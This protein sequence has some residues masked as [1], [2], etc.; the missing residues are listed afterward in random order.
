MKRYSILRIDSKDF[1]DILQKFKKLTRFS[2]SLTLKNDKIK[3]TITMEVDEQSTSFESYP[4]L[5]K[6]L[7]ELYLETI[8]FC[9]NQL[10]F[11]LYPLILHKH[12]KIGKRHE[13]HIG[14]RFYPFE[15]MILNILLDYKDLKLSKIYRYPQYP[16][17]EF[18]DQLHS[19][20][21]KTKDR[22]YDPQKQSS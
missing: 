13:N 21:F 3:G 4:K 22:I 16:F 19:L 6:H 18:S 5:I 1:D 7:I 12:I 10:N 20:L 9:Q 17:I 15:S 2:R 14:L 8:D 11:K